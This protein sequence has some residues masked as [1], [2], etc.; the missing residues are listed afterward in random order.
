MKKI[1]TIFL[2]VAIVLIGIVALIVMIRLPLTEG[3]AANLDWFSIYSDPFIIYG[4]IVSIP[5][6]IALYQAFMLFGYIGRNEIF[7]LSSVKALQVIRYCAV[8]LG[9]SIILVGLY[10][11][12]FHHADDDPT[13]FIALCIAT[14]FISIIVAT[15]ANVCEWIIRSG[16]G[17]K[18]GTDI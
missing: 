5:F 14:A 18:S 11:V 10:I 8:A 13:G 7:S 1:S 9:I 6:F 12:A 3:R 15:F 4:Y 16:I 2:R 17:M